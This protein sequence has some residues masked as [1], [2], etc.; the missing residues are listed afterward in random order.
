MK[1]VKCE[2]A[3]RKGTKAKK[4]HK[5]KKSGQVNLCLCALVNYVRRK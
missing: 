5:I 4:Q 2:P 3:I 1:M